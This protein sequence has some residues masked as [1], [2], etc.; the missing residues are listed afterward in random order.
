MRKLLWA[1]FIVAGLVSVGWFAQFYYFNLRGAY[2]AFS[3]PTVKD[4]E[5]YVRENKGV[6]VVPKGYEMQVFASGLVKPRVLKYDPSGVLL[7]SVPTKGTIVALPDRNNDGKADEVVEVIGGLNK[8]HGF[9]F[10]SP[11]EDAP[12]QLY[13]AESDQLAVYD[14]YS[15]L[16]ATNKKKL[17]ELPDAGYNQHYTRTLFLTKVS[18]D[19]ALLIS[20]GSSCNVCNEE[21]SRR[22]KVLFYNLRTG[23]SGVYASGLRN[24]VFLAEHPVTGKIWATEMG[25]D[26]LGDDIPPD[27]INIIEQNKN[28]GWPTCYGKNVHDTAFDKN[29]YIRNPCMDPF[30]IP[31]LIDLPAHSAPLGL[32]FV[33]NKGWPAEVQGDLLVAFHGSWNRTVPTGYKITRI[34]FDD[35]GKY[36]GME[37]FVTGWFE[38]KIKL[39]RPVDMLMR[40]DDGMYISDDGAGVIYLLQRTKN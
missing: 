16:K 3:D 35:E 40:T 4:V 2:V 27:E 28:Y 37:D 5:A 1:I 26:L 30:E 18:G 24:A 8:P 10:Y 19:D 17:L 21:D 32:A 23:Q 6:F 20:V 15:G 34:M 39:G 22:A 36:V 13:V 14:Y 11:N 9:A 25:R 31:S 7:V 33:P 38:N 12:Y 29:T